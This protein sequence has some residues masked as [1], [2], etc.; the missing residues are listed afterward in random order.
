MVTTC[1]I[2]I[3]VINMN[4]II[5]AAF[6]SS[7]PFALT[8]PIVETPSLLGLWPCFCWPGCLPLVCVQEAAWFGRSSGLWGHWYWSDCSPQ[9]L[10]VL[11]QTHLWCLSLILLVSFT[12]I[13]I[14][15]HIYQQTFCLWVNNEMGK[16]DYNTLPLKAP[17]PVSLCHLWWCLM[18]QP[19]KR[20]I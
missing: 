10:H 1:T 19:H 11:P 6:L 5:I 9:F 2:I 20:I 14:H 15:T 7:L 18:C 17:Q 8:I 12:L 16:A 4:Y 13:H 3:I